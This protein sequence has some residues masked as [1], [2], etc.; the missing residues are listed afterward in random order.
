MGGAT[1]P[2]A[3]PKIHRNQNELDAPPRPRDKPDKRT[4]EEEDEE[5][6]PIAEVSLMEYIVFPSPPTQMDS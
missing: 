2:P 4:R 3:P 6:Q 1:A 5:L